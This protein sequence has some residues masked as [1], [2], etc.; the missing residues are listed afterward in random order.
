MLVLVQYVQTGSNVAG[1]GK[2]NKAAPLHCLKNSYFCPVIFA[3]S[4]EIPHNVFIT[5]FV[6]RTGGKPKR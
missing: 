4:D 5:T 1:D 6:F 2:N 3:D